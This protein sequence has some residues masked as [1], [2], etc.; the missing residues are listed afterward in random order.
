MNEA[1][2][3]E[4][5]QGAE[6]IVDE[7]RSP[8]EI[9]RRLLAEHL[10]PKQLWEMGFRCGFT[11]TGGKTGVRYL[12]GKGRVSNVY[13]LNKHGQPIATMCFGPS[14]QNYFRRELPEA[15]VMPRRKSR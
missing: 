9:A 10:T 7:G 8:A 3:S 11:V 13:V 2:I 14:A 12:I 15:D 6:S 5:G 1:T 4:T